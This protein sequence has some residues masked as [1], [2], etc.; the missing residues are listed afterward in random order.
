MASNTSILARLTIVH[1]VLADQPFA[2]LVDLRRRC[3]LRGGGRRATVAQQLAS[4]TK[5][6]TI[7]QPLPVLSSMVR[8]YVYEPGGA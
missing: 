5:E 1:A 3:A 8:S 6:T 4:M 7:D 2:T